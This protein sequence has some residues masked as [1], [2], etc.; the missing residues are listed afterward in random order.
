MVISGLNLIVYVDQTP[1]LIKIKNQHI[2]IYIYLEVGGG[3]GQGREDYVIICDHFK[4]EE[5]HF[6]NEKC[7]YEL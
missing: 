2:Y 4:K 1:T 7:S 5:N 3:R 6:K